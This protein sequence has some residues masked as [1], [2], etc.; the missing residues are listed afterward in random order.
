MSPCRASGTSSSSG[1]QG[2][3]RTP[4]VSD[5]VSVH[6]PL[7]ENTH[8]LIG[9]RELRLMK[10]SARLVN[11]SRGGI[12]DEDALARALT[13]GRIAGAALDVYESEPEPPWAAR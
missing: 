12:V 5:Y 2:P 10:R 1:A 3:G 6:V 11:S 4:L 13:E 8:G 9:D 7:T